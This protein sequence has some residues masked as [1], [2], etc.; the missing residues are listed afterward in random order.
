[1]GIVRRHKRQTASGKVTTVRQHTRDYDSGPGGNERRPAAEDAAPAPRPPAL[2]E[3]DETWW[4]DSEPRPEP[5]MDSG[6]EPER[7][8][9]PAFLSM[10]DEMRDWRS[11]R[12]EVPPATPDTSPLGRVLGNDTQEGA[13][14]FARLKAY[15]EA[16]YDGPIDQDGNIPDPDDPRERPALEALAYMRDQH[17]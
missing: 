2:R 16:G 6:E 4:D 3:N 8:P 17:G 12:V 10:Q 5:W 13:D 7:E 9:G 14:K 1:M 15:R 11:R